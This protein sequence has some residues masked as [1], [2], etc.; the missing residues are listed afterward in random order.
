MSNTRVYGNLTE[1]QRTGFFLGLGPVA[2]LLSLV[3]LSLVIVLGSIFGSWLLAALVGLAGATALFFTRSTP[4]RDSLL[5]Q[6]KDRIMFT[7][8]RKR[9]RTKFRP[10]MQRSFQPPGMAASLHLVDLPVPSDKSYAAIANP[11]QRTLT[12]LFSIAS[13]GDEALSQSTINSY[14]DSWG[15][16]LR[17]MGQVSDCLAAQAVTETYPDPGVRGRVHL[18]ESMSDDAPELARELIDVAAEELPAGRLAMRHRLA[19]VFNQRGRDWDTCAGEVAKQIRNLVPDLES[20]GLSPRLMGHEE[21]T[22]FFRRSYSPTD[23]LNIDL[24]RAESATEFNLDFSEVGPTAAEE[25]ARGFIHDEFVSTSYAAFQF[26]TDGFIEQVLRP[27]LEPN[28]DLPIKRV[29]ITY[30]PYE[31][32]EARARIDADHRDAMRAARR[33]SRGQEDPADQ[34]RL[35]AVEQS[36]M[37]IQAGHGYTRA[38]IIVT[39]TAPVGADRDATDILIDGMGR[40]ASLH[41]RPTNFHHSANFAASLGAGILLERGGDGVLSNAI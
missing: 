15:I 35:A 1:R 6:M 32:G 10:A 29:C 17:D 12:V 8:L 37:E 27:V 30:R 23:A 13:K 40:A 38:G 3:L 9:S 25:Q 18:E 20:S 14:V 22:E 16:F 41:M 24:A 39:V 31:R 28:Y 11:A 19:I 5:T 4:N 36:R 33:V 21:I 2:S 7:F 34:V 26:P